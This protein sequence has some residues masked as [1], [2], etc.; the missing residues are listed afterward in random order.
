MLTPP[1]KPPPTTPQKDASEKRPSAL[2]K[3]SSVPQPTNVRPYWNEKVAAWSQK[4]W[5]SIVSDSA[6]TSSTPHILQNSWFS[7]TKRPP[8]GTNCPKISLQSIKEEESPDENPTLGKK[9][10]IRTMATCN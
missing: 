5:L 3:N 7:S 6:V 4:L 2:P 9:R 1:P 8:M 10:K